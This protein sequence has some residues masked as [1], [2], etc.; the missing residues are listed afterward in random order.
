MRRAL[1]VL[2]VLRG[3]FTKSK[4]NGQGGQTATP[5]A[6]PE[7][8]PLFTGLF[9][10][11]GRRVDLSYNARTGKTAFPSMYRAKKFAPRPLLV[12]LPDAFLLFANDTR[13]APDPPPRQG[14]V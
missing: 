4:Y 2:C 10:T 13:A 1:F 11:S 7:F 5:Q 8:R 12:A 6:L 14:R 9:L 3:Q